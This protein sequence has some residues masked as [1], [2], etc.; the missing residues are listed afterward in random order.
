MLLRSDGT[1]AACGA[2]IGGQCNI[3]ASE[4]FHPLPDA[5]D[6]WWGVC[7][8][9]GRI[10]EIEEMITPSVLPDGTRD[11]EPPCSS[12]VAALR[13]DISA[14]LADVNEVTTTHEENLQNL[15]ADINPTMRRI[16]DILTRLD[17]LDAASS[18]SKDAVAS[19]NTS[20]IGVVR[21]PEVEPI[22][23][24]VRTTVTQSA[25]QV[26]EQL[27]TVME[28]RCSSLERLSVQLCERM[29][30]LEGNGGTLNDSDN[31]SDPWT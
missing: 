12:E 21:V 20:L 11:A 24:F 22:L 6:L 25:R 23:E 26:A 10:L 5:R 18:A 9:E 30:R 16:P 31:D 28:A 17:S 19:L 13:S 1:D 14:L 29:E 3:P 27:C 7:L 8:L 15:I 4:T 2:N